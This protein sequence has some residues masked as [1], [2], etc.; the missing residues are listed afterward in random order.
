MTM[1]LGLG[2]LR[3]LYGSLSVVG[4]SWD[5]WVFLIDYVMG[6]RKGLRFDVIRWAICFRSSGVEYL[7]AIQF[8]SWEALSFESH[9]FH[10]DIVI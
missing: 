3:S 4:L 7:V 10:F 1:S 2:Y 5:G 9:V 6:K 8:I